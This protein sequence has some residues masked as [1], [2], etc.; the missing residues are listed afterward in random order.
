MEV[1]MALLNVASRMMSMTALATPC[2]AS[3]YVH[4]RVRFCI[5]ECVESNPASS[6]GRFMVSLVSGALQGRVPGLGFLSGPVLG[7]SA[8]H[9][10]LTGCCKSWLNQE[11][12]VSNSGTTY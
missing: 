12:T 11:A 10:M 7:L 8:V 3:K 1:D 5:V 9:P 6:S 4:V 2:D